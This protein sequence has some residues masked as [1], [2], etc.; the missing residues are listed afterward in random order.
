MSRIKLF[1]II[2]T[3]WLI[4]LA[5]TIIIF[6]HATWLSIVVFI[7]IACLFS[8]ILFWFTNQL[9]VKDKAIEDST[10]L[11]EKNERI[12]TQNQL[13]LH[14][15]HLIRLAHYDSLTSLPNRI[16]FNEILNKILSHALRHAKTMAILFINL[17]K[18]K[19][20]NVALG[21]PCGDLVLKEMASRFTKAIRTEDIIARLGG[22]E[23]IV[24]LSDISHPK[25][26]SPIAKKILEVCSQTFKIDQ[27]ELLMTCSIGICIFPND[28][29]TLEDIQKNADMAMDKAKR[30]G[31]NN[32]QYYTQEMNLEAV[33][34]IKLT[35]ALRRAIR[36]NQF[37]L[38]FQPKLT[39]EDG[40]ISGVEAL[41]RWNH[42]ELGIVDPDKF[43]PLAEESGIILQIGEWALWEACRINKGWQDQGYLPICMS[44]N[45]SPIQF[46][47]QDIPQ[48]VEKV[49]QETGLEPK[50]LEL[51]ITETTVMENVKENV[52][53]LQ[54]LQNMG[55]S[56]AIDDF[57]TG[58]TSISYL[59]QFP[60]SILKIDKNFIKG[61]TDNP[62]DLA[63]T[64]AIIALGHSLGMK[65]VAEG[66]ETE[67]QLTILAD[68]KCDY[69]QG[70]YLS[71]PLPAN[72]FVLQL[73]KV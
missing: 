4:F 3:S 18:F 38:C 12:E 17:D 42:P 62:N 73:T 40:M 37:E 36:E 49:L 8:V 26:A 58:Y 23:F 6:Y 30:L 64:K 67:E 19:N 69:V 41:I 28:G 70:Y 43:I 45:L 32:F 21:H 15:E 31:G 59:K 39:L 44:V 16:F 7:L 5:A 27:Q 10:L 34:H 54:Q 61:L 9:I 60:I 71:P 72:K 20:I 29:T 68:N 57:G 13:I 66:V 2:A 48:L 51:E 47:Q 52:F 63:I 65:L 56:V 46:R 14:K 33:E 24:L 35:T 22:D 1:S 50:Y 53:K 11:A 25:Y 55:V